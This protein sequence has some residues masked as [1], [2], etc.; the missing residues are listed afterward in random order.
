MNKTLIA[1]A[2]SLFNKSGNGDSKFEL[3]CK[4]LIPLAIDP[5]FLHSSGLAAGGDGG[6]DGWSPLGATDKI[7]YGFSIRQDAIT[8]I[9]S[10]IKKIPSN[11]FVAIRLFTN[12]HISEREKV[13]IYREN[14]NLSI[15]IY[16]SENLVEFISRHPELEQYTDLPKIQSGIAMDYAR[17]HDPFIHQHAKIQRYLSRTYLLV[18][19]ESG[20]NVEL[21]ATA[22]VKRTSSLTIMLSPAGYGKTCALEQIHQG[23]LDESIDYDIPPVFV[24]LAD[25]VQG[26]LSQMIDEAM[27]VSGDYQATNFLL[28]LDGYDEVAENERRSLNKEI[29]RILRSTVYFRKVILTSRDFVP[30]RVFESI[31]L[32]QDLVFLSPI[33]RDGIDTLF[34]EVGITNGDEF[35]DNP[36]FCC[37]SNNVFYVTN[38]INY[39]V[40]RNTIARNV[41]ELFL[42]L[43]NKELEQVFR[44]TTPPFRLVESIA[45]F[46]VLSQKQSIESA[47]I[48]DKLSLPDDFAATL[49]FSHKS[50]L[51]YL[52][53]RKIA[54]QPLEQMK[55]IVT[56]GHL[57]IP[58]LTNTIGF[59]LNIL[60][61]DTDQG[62]YQKFEQFLKW[63]MHGSG[64]AK[65]LLQIETD[66]VSPQVCQDVFAAVIEQ[67]ALTGNLF[68][69]SDSLIRF[70]LQR[71]ESVETNV[72]TLIDKIILS[73]D[74]ETHHFFT[75]TLQ[76]LCY[77]DIGAIADSEQE[78][79][80]D[81][82]IVLLGPESIDQNQ[83]LIESLLYI[84]PKFETI[85][86]LN[87]QNLHFIVERV[88]SLP[89]DS[90]FD[91]L[92]SLLMKARPVLD[93]A[94]YYK[95]YHFII[96]RVSRQGGG[97]ARLVPEQISD[98]D[99]MEM[100][101]YTEWNNFIPL[102][103]SFLQA[104]E[105]HVWM[106][107]NDTT[108]NICGEEGYRHS[109]RRD[110]DKLYRVIFSQV[111]SQHSRKLLGDDNV[112]ALVILLQKDSEEYHLGPIWV[113]MRD[114]L[115]APLLQEVVFRFLARTDFTYMMRQG[116]ISFH[117]EQIKT[118]EHFDVFMDT[119]FANGNPAQKKYFSEFC[120]RLPEKGPLTKHMLS[121]ISDELRN[122]ILKRNENVA[123]YKEQ[124][125]SEEDMK[126]SYSVCFHPKILIVQTEAIFSTFEVDALTENHL[127]GTDPSEALEKKYP[128]A[129]Y[130][131]R[132]SIR[133]SESTIEL[134]KIRDFI[135]SSEWLFDFMVPL[136]RYCEHK[137]IKVGDFK[138]EEV[139][140]TKAWATRILEKYPLTKANSVF[141]NIHINLSFILRQLPGNAI[142]S[143]FISMNKNKIIGLVFSGFA[144]VLAGRY[145]VDAESFSLEYL[146]KYLSVEELIEFVI[147]NFLTAFR[148]KEVMIAICGYVSLRQNHL[149]PFQKQTI[150]QHLTQYI[151]ENLSS[152]HCSEI[153]KLS[154]EVGVLISDLDAERFARAL[155]PNERN[156]GL[157][158]NAAAGYLLYPNK[159]QS[160]EHERSLQDITL[161]AYEQT[162]DT[163]LKKTL[164]E[165][166]LGMNKRAGNV[167]VFY[168][169]YLMSGDNSTMN[170]SFGM[171]GAAAKQL[172]TAELAHLPKVQELFRYSRNKKHSERRDAIRNMALE[173][174]RLI[175]AEVD[176]EEEFILV[177]NS[178]KAIAD[179]GN[180]Y[181]YRHIQDFQ[182]A[183][184][185]RTYVPLTI[186]E[187]SNM[188]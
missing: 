174:Y 85:T 185:E 95:L 15:T 81:F 156:T 146:E 29:S 188:V 80:T 182:D 25:Y 178:M 114:T 4:K 12:Q 2:L 55:R 75:L 148:S 108:E 102:T 171:W 150:R 63:C 99:R 119:Y 33:T 181:L 176:N 121:V 175:A 34:T 30:A 3:L 10:E 134:K 19:T 97:I 17:R 129:M 167:F 70:M 187:I 82:L 43:T 152:T 84:I 158:H 107:L 54:R 160:A 79:L 6:L 72:K 153:Y 66:K 100:V 1:F 76:D 131:L 138:D 37:F 110:F 28:L 47:A 11:E 137:K 62:D 179:D 177:I 41:H 113:P 147:R 69:R 38:F 180:Q 35:W 86:G 183:F 21:S 9:K 157:E 133:D 173:S 52:A 162:E 64:N 36:F 48:G 31:P 53:A 51:E 32:K 143:N 56:K 89:M 165:Y 186:D 73:K 5:A 92:C 145:T 77:T 18:G 42:F 67:E 61:S 118:I 140:E 96:E 22:L 117:N 144:D 112:D 98:N 103:E 123:K 170:R 151:N 13:K 59:V 94:T 149:K 83:Q 168:A 111:R 154:N 40:D 159:E 26:T 164:A 45:L 166:Y 106:L 172:A 122:G 20:E 57:L 8:K 16:D 50:I 68:E 93:S 14:E 24:R 124:E 127:Y 87:D 155:T 46:M 109:S 116:F 161:S 39:Y 65:R 125:I 27:H 126:Q 139:A 49:Q 184:A 91:N 78:R 71:E 58:H 142:D 23:I 101:R 88:L 105:E 136:T 141:R 74:S 7:K 115:D 130:L 132:N 128:F 90:P 60:V 44:T 135:L 104:S 169:D 163:F 120:Y